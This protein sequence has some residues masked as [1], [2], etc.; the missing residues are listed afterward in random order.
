MMIS[1]MAVRDLQRQ[2]DSV[3]TGVGKLL[4]RF[5][6]PFL[7]PGVPRQRTAAEPSAAPA[8]TLQLVETADAMVPETMPAPVQDDRHRWRRH[9]QLRG[10]DDSLPASERHARHAA[11]RGLFNARCGDYEGARLA[12][13]EAAREGS[14]DLTALPGFWSLPRAGLTAAVLAYEDAGRLRDSS[15]LA[16][17]L[18]THLRP[19]PLTRPSTPIGERHQAT[20]N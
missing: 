19:R 12:F 3:S 7:H 8:A 5:V 14:L 10:R 2:R 9:P 1:D 16:A 20:G 13:A 17:H 15:A 18:R 6:Q 11:V 4:S